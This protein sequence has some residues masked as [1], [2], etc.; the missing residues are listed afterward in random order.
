MV[1]ALQALDAVQAGTVK[2][3]HTASSFYIGKNP[4]FDFTTGVPFGLNTR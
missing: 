3:A 4:A 2:A 1:P